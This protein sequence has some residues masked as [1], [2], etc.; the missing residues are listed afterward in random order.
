MNAFTQVREYASRSSATELLRKLGLKAHDYNTFI[1]HDSTTGKYLLAL[2]AATAHAA[3]MTAIAKAGVKVRGKASVE[4]PDIDETEALAAAKPATVISRVS[5]R[6]KAG[7]DANK[8]RTV[9][10]VA[11]ELIRAGQ[12]NAQVFTALDAEFQIGE[13]KKGYPSWYRRH[14]MAKFGEDYSST[15]K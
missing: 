2:D 7:L 12:T 5:A 14:L 15:A 13:G 10:S 9:T 8:G 1:T 11:L 3:S 6:R 4:G